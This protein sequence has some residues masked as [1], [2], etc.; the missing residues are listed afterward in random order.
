MENY[1]QVIPFT[2]S[3]LEYWIQFLLS[4]Q[5]VEVIPRYF[6]SDGVSSF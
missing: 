2:P 5:L 1:P 6:F 3:Y 4:L